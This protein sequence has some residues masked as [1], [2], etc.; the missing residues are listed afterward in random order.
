MYILCIIMLYFCLYNIPWPYTL[1]YIYTCTYTLH[2]HKISSTSCIHRFTYNASKTCF[3]L[4]ITPK[5]QFPKENPCLFQSHWG[6]ASKRSPWVPKPRRQHTWWVDKWGG[7]VLFKIP[8]ISDVPYTPLKMN[9]WK[10]GTY[11]NFP[12]GNE[13]HLP[14]RFSFNDN[15]PY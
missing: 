6:S 2:P 13:H 5:K 7:G 1:L 4:F 12:I 8:L 11:N 9:R 14:S 3:V 10:D 15:V